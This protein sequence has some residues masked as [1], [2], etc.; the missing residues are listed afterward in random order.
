V[1]VGIVSSRPA[2]PQG[3]ERV[4]DRPPGAG[5]PWGG[6]SSPIFHVPRDRRRAASRGARRT[7]AEDDRH[8]TKPQPGRETLRFMGS[9][10]G[11]RDASAL[12][13]PKELIPMDFGLG[14]DLGRPGCRLPS[15]RLL[16]EKEKRPEMGALRFRPW[17][18]TCAGTSLVAQLSDVT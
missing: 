11:R 13:S 18:Q 7:D 2:G 1:E 14:I 9:G 3:G 10:A 8:Q 5:S 4:Q 15:F 6:Q 12:P 16:I 17:G